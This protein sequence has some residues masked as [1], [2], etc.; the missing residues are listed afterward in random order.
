MKQCF[1][2]QNQPA[3]GLGLLAVHPIGDRMVN[4]RDQV[5]EDAAQIARPRVQLPGHAAP[6][7]RYPPMVT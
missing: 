4:R 5:A 1:A 7:T 2:A 6:R 3:G